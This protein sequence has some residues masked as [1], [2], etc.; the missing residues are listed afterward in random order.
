V[1]YW[2]HPESDSLWASNKDENAKGGDAALVEEL[3]HQEYLTMQRLQRQ[4]MTHSEHKRPMH[5]MRVDKNTRHGAVC[6][7]G[8]R[9]IEVTAPHSEWLEWALTALYAAAEKRLQ[10]QNK[11]KA[12]EPSRTK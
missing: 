11:E 1:R 12:S 9:R 2:Y 3:T 8:G 5:F 7:A 10:R 6:F 4:M